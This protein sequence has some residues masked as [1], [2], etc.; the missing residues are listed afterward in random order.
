MVRMLT[1]TWWSTVGISLQTEEEEDDE[2]EFLSGEE[3]VFNLEDLHW[4]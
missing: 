3:L 1:M 4:N 2:D